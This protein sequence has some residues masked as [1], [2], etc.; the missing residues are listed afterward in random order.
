[1]R[2]QQQ[3]RAAR[4]QLLD[5]RQRGADARVVGD[6]RTFEGHVEVDPDEDALALD[7]ELVERSH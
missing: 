6:A 5:R 1:V 7:V 2:R 4:A 3:A